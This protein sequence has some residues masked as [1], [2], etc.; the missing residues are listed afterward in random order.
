MATFVVFVYD[1]YRKEVDMQIL[2]TFKTEQDARQFIAPLLHPAFTS[3][4][5]YVSIKGNVFDQEIMPSDYDS[6]RENSQE[7]SRK[8]FLEEEVETE[9]KFN[10]RIRE[11]M[12]K[13]GM[14]RWYNRVGISKVPGYG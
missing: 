2:A 4:H 5:E 6:F 3:E 11:T 13:L 8:S 1:D 10:I 9:N 7:L 14:N 12:A